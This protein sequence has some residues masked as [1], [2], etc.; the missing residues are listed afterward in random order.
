MPAIPDFSDTVGFPRRQIVPF[1]R[2]AC[3]QTDTELPR[4]SIEIR[5]Y[6]QR[7]R[8]TAN[9]IALYALIM[10]ASTL[11]FFHRP[12]LLP[13]PCRYRTPRTTA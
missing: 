10:K 8:S 5:R 12:F 3:I 7:I 13:V 6:L 4:R 2:T 1:Y 9:R 11:C